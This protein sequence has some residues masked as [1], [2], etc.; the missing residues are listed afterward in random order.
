MTYNPLGLSATN[1]GDM[2]Q[3]RVVYT[4]ATTAEA[5]TALKTLGY[6]EVPEG[7]CFINQGTA[8]KIYTAWGK[9]RYY[10]DLLSSLSFSPRIQIHFKCGEGTPLLNETVQA[11]TQA[12]TRLSGGTRITVFDINTGQDITGSLLA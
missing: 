9:A 10:P 3:T 2:G 12:L 6:N 4:D 11:C 8:L 5:I 1:Q 7:G